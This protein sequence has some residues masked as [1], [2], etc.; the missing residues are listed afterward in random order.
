MIYTC[1]IC[2]YST[3]RTSNYKKHLGTKIH[4]NNLEKNNIDI[5]DDIIFDCKYCDLIF[6]DEFTLQLH[7]SECN[8]NYKRIIINLEEKNKQLTNK[9]IELE[10]KLNNKNNVL[11]Y[12]SYNYDSAP[13]LTSIPDCSAINNYKESDSFKFGGD[14]IYYY[15]TKKLFKLIGNFII[16]HYKKKNPEEQSLWASDI[17]RSIF[18]VRNEEEWFVDADLKFITETIINPI[19]GYIK[20]NLDIYKI[21]ISKIM[22]D[23]V[24]EDLYAKITDRI[25][26]TISDY[27][28]YLKD[29]NMIIDQIKNDGL[30][31]DD[32]L[33]KN[34]IRFIAPSFY[35]NKPLR[36]KK[37]CFLTL[38]DN[39]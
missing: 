38:S 3:N 10:A 23:N 30:M 32:K 19:F 27:G 6:N 13:N 9:I 4:V 5:V 22:S 2:E 28:N 21:F 14:I 18:Y 34:I 12:I 15:R 35:I 36:N 16:N 39:P 7:I 24:D 26:T 33:I 37:N 25:I 11:A 8:N 1:E 31:K 29:D 17:A 20:E